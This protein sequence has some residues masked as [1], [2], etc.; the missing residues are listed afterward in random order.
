MQSDVF[1]KIRGV[2]FVVEYNMRTLLMYEKLTNANQS[3]N[4][5]KLEDFCFPKTLEGICKLLYCCVVTSEEASELDITYEEFI[6][7]LGTSFDYYVLLTDF[8]SFL[9]DIKRLN[10]KFLSGGESQE[11]EANEE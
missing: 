9:N 10:G 1:M 11:E 5:N 8:A 3:F 7:E 6:D 2:E 4:P